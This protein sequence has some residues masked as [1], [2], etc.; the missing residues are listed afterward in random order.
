MRQRNLSLNGS[1]DWKRPLLFSK[2]AVA[3]DILSNQMKQD[4]PRA[5]PVNWRRPSIT[6]FL[7]RLSNDFSYPR[8]ADS[9]H[10]NSNT[11]NPTLTNCGRKS[12]TELFIRPKSPIII[13]SLPIAT[14]VV[15]ANET[16]CEELLE[17]QISSNLCKPQDAQETQQAQQVME[18][19]LQ[20]PI[21]DISQKFSRRIS[22]ITD[23]DD[24]Y[25]DI[26]SDDAAHGP[27][28]T[29]KAS[30]NHGMAMS[31]LAG[32][33]EENE[34]DEKKGRLKMHY[35]R[36]L[37]QKLKGAKS[38]CVSFAGSSTGEDGL[39]MNSVGNGEANYGEGPGAA[40]MED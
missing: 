7:D 38:S 29:V 3:G 19:Q 14:S 36:R 5:Y 6:S 9:E 17:N 26:D 12:S 21:P 1:E 27:Q 10:D 11:E 20:I 2:N 40:N 18:L 28:N 33:E 15:A 13:D 34:A 16:T 35:G 23:N 37:A 39:R 22:E 4:V 30:L 32:G 25:E 31:D 8:N 24:D